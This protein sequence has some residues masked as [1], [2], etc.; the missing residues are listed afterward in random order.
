MSKSTIVAFSGGKDSTAMALSLRDRGEEF[1][2]LFTPT[3]DELPDLFEHIDNVVKLTGADLIIPQNK[4]LYEWID[5]MHMLPSTRA[6][7]CTRA[8]KI[9]PCIL[10]MKKNPGHRLAVGL[11][12]DEEARQGL[13]SELIETV[14]PLREWGWGLKEVQAFIKTKPVTVPR[15]TDC[16]LCPYQQLGE[17]YRLWRDYPARYQLGVE[18]ED[19]IGHTIRSPSRDM[20]PA[21]LRELAI[22]FS[23][24]RKIR[25][26]KEE[27]QA[28]RICTL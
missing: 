7:W 17:W 5:K 22:E 24:G 1:K 10:W 15:R 13:Y 27:N 14:F 11:R 8:I 16:A 20:W 9:E 6:R 4:T 18:Y 23:Q 19:K 3:G 12:A 26:Y 28:C 25:G 2:L 21:A